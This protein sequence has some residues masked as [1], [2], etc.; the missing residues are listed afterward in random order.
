MPA[1][2][3]KKT[4]LCLLMQANFN[5]KQ[6]GISKKKLINKFCRTQKKKKQA[7]SFGKSCRNFLRCC[8]TNEFWQKLDTNIQVFDS[9]KDKITKLKNIKNFETGFFIFDQ[10]LFTF[11]TSIKWKYLVNLSNFE[12]ILKVKCIISY[13]FTSFLKWFKSVKE[14][15]LRNY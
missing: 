15:F 3:N 5:F 2:N 6:E 9:F 13:S 4:I 14:F 8:S 7:Y 10:K 11:K 1:F 12:R